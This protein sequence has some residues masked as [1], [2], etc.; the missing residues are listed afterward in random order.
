MTRSKRL[1][2]LLRRDL[3]RRSRESKIRLLDRLMV[4]R[5]ISQ[6]R[7][8]LLVVRLLRVIRMTEDLIRKDRLNKN[9]L[10]PDL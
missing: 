8:T 6:I 4:I 7:L 9:I 10:N 1:L 5:L 2:L 3:L